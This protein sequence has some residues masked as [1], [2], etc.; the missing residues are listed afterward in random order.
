LPRGLVP[1]A[2]ATPETIFA[3]NRA[4]GRIALSVAAARGATRRGR[5]A[6]DG[7]LRVRFPGAAARELEAVLV[8]TAG[9]MTGGDRFGIAIAAGPDAHLLFGTAAAEKIY[10]SLGPATDMT[11]T[12]ALRA[13]ARLRW[14]PQET[15]LFDRARLARRI[16][17]EMEEGASLLLAEAIV[18]GRSAMGETVV[19]GEIADRW[20]VRV[21]GKLVFAESL[22]LGGAIARKLAEPAAAAGGCALA[23]VLSV[24]GDARQVEAVRAH[25]DRFAGEVGI[26]C[27]NG[28]AVARLCARDGAALRRDLA[29]VLAA[30][31]SGSL[32]KLWLN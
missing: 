10:R 2:I 22:R 20:R 12:L 3:A 7:S 23:T 26:S 29:A 30:L 31:D 17:V 16:D 9:G 24:P 13:G 25:A 4:E 28:I 21:G 1:T 8:N 5:V 11:V 15:I 6:E 18:F 19:E 14:L 27:W 32:P